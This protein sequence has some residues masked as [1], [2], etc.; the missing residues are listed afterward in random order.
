MILRTLFLHPLGPALILCLGGIV[1]AVLRRIARRKAVLAQMI[2]GRPLSELP[3]SWLYDLRSPLALITVLAATALLAQLRGMSPRPALAWTWQPLTVAGSILEWRID[4]W[5]WTIS[6]VI[7]ALAGVA[8]LLGEG[9]TAPAVRARLDLVGA[10]AERTLWLAAAAL[11]FVLSANILTLACCWIALDAALAVRLRLAGA[12]EA[13]GRAWGMLSLSSVLLL[14]LLAMLGEDGIRASVTGARLTDMELSLLWLVALIRAGVYPFHFWLTG[15][16]STQRDHWIPV[17]LIAPV[18]GLWL[19][20]RVH[21]LAPEGWLRRPEWIALGAL[22]LLGTALVAWTSEDPGR[23][24]RWI[25]LNRASL[26]VLAAYTVASP[27]PGALVW[28]VVTFALGCALL[29]G[30]QAARR[31]FGWQAPSALAALTLWGLPG[32]VGFLAH[33]VLV[34]PTDAALAIPLFGVV[35][36]SEVLLVAA[37]W[38]AVFRDVAA[39]QTRGEVGWRAVLRVGGAVAVLAVPLIGFGLAPNALA[40]LAGAPLDP[41]AA[42]LRAIMA[43]TR[44]SIWAG[45]ALAALLGGLLGIYRQA[46]LGQMRGWQAAISN[47]AS[48]EWLYNAVAAGFKLAAGGLQYFATLGEGEGYLGWLALASLI[49]WVLLS[50]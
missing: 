6:A 19:L 46:I 20:G 47:I 4:A 16:H 11:V 17:Y 26:A 25:A 50:T 2:A 41:A 5:N 33:S 38:E 1:L 35:I 12:Q 36:L 39:P 15:H 9:I 8:L 10:E 23:R 42:S 31:M 44:R 28:S 29:V 7:I 48:L 13:A 21:A 30:G 32:T 27:S 3:R 49:I 22:A 40:S 43:E 34:F 45:L 14:V 18:A 24:W 37:L